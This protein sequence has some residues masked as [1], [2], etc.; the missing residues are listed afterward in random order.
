MNGVKS[1]LLLGLLLAL[2]AAAFI[3]FFT[4]GLAR[5]TFVFYTGNDGLVTVEQRMLRIS[6]GDTPVSGGKGSAGN[7]VSEE[8]R[9]SL[10]RETNIARYVEEALLGPVSP[11]SLPL[12]PRETRLLSLLYRD[13]VVYVGLS[14]DAALPPLEVLQGEGV[15]RSMTTLY[16]GIR[17]NFPYVR[18]IR[19]FIAGKAAYPDDEFRQAGEF[20]LKNG[21]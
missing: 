5:R 18:D 14:E 8:S 20:A 15:L 7:P 4:L 11:N 21:I 2:A 1:G 3:E 6:K 9:R 12:F 19:F 10:S 17:R 13:E 16:S